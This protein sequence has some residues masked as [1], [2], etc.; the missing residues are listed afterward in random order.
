LRYEPD[1]ENQKL[2]DKNP[3]IYRPQGFVT[4]DLENLIDELIV[5]DGGFLRA[6]SFGEFEKHV[7]AAGNK[8]SLIG[9]LLALYR[10]FASETHPVLARMLVTQA[11]LCNLLMTTYKKLVGIQGLR[12]H[13]DAFINSAEVRSQLRW[14]ETDGECAELKTVH[15]YL[16]GCLDWIEGAP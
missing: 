2:R 15:S 12:Q 4:G 9:E 16:V 3:A 14:R 7:H 5:N 10:G 13:L 1:W 8:D 11:G 6:C